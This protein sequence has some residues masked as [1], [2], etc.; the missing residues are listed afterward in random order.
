MLSRFAALMMLLVLSVCA[1]LPPS[2]QAQAAYRWVDKAGQVHYSDVPPPPDESQKVERKQVS[3]NKV[4]ETSTVSFAMRKAMQDFPLT[5]YTASNCKD[6]CKLA[7]DFLGQR[8]VPFSE[9]NI[10]TSEDMEAF[11]KA[12]GIEEVFVPVLQAGVGGKIEK[13]FE[14]NAWRRL[15]ET[16]GYPPPRSGVTTIAPAAP[17]PPPPY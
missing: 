16:A 5:L 9:M 14:E 17:P 2:A 8:K 6:S 10:Q 4:D 11:K 12:T 1:A 15:L 7:R 13:G 3:G